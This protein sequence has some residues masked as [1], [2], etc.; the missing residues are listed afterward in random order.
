MYH[1]QIRE[2]S[3]KWKVEEIKHFDQEDLDD[4]D[5][6]ILD[7]QE[8]VFVWVGKGA[9]DEERERGPKFAEVILLINIK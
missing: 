4:D 5:I 6:M 8:E 1:C 9:S 2:K 3:H 7:V